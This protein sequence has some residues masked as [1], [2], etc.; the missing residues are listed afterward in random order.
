MSKTL[1]LSIFAL[2]S[3]ASLAHTTQ[4]LN[5]YWQ[6][7]EYLEAHPKQK[8][9]T[10][11]LSEEVR[12][13]PTPLANQQEKPVTISVVYPGQQISDYWSRNIKA[14]E[15]R[16]EKLGI[17]Y[18]INQVFTRPNIDV[19]Q[20]SLSLLEAVQNNSDYLIFTLDTTRH[21][22]FIEHVLSSTDTKLILQNITTPVRAWDHQQ[23]FMYVGFDHIKGT[24]V[25]ENYY[26]ETVKG[27][28][29]Y[30]VLYFSEGYVSDAR[31][32]TFIEEMSH[33][34]NYKLSSSFYTKA[35]RDSGYQAALTAIEKDPNL[36]FI[37][38]CSTDVALGAA[39]ALTDLNRTDILLNG[40]GGGTAELEAIA[41]KRL[42]VTVMRM[43]DDTGIAMAEAIK[44][45]IE[46]RA[47]PHV[48]SGDFELVTS[49]D[50]AKKLEKLKQRA[51]R[52]SDQ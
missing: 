34:D 39:D 51:F 2:Y 42:D 45:D 37:Y 46:G 11:Q 48:Y 38:A 40:W 14:F 32:D 9:L 18:S 16:L 15:T 20:Q 12:R 36:K 6:Y 13:Y 43:N 17:R 3:S 4:V 41:D 7:D 26:K 28:S 44:W 25:I 19:R 35:T 27:E 22:K 5:G 23:P 1:I 29:R 8:Q 52:Y 24:R 50:S 31:G 49:E 47:V 21:R 33:H 30:S 10:A